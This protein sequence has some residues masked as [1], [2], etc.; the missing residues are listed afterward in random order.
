MQWKERHILIRIIINHVCVVAFTSV[1]HH[2]V[3]TIGITITG[4]IIHLGTRHHPGDTTIT[5][6][7]RRAVNNRTMLAALFPQKILSNF[8]R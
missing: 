7:T 6:S 4:I 8:F 5:K 1:L 3:I 2:L